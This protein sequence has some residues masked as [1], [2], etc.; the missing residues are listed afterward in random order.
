M[1]DP[2]SRVDATSYSGTGHAV[3]IILFVHIIPLGTRHNNMT[4]NVLKIW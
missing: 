2:P 3:R 4:R 1:V